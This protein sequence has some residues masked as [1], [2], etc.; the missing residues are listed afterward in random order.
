MKTLST[1]ALLRKTFNWG[2]SLQFRDSVLFHH[3]GEHRTMHADV[4]LGTSWL[5]GKRKWSEC[6]TEWTLSESNLRAHSHSDKFPLM[7]IRLIYLLHTFLN[8]YFNK[9]TPA[10]SVLSLGMIFF[11]T[12]IVHYMAS[13]CLFPL[14]NTVS[15]TS[16][17]PIVYH[18]CK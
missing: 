12:T 8:T 10:N 18:S 13:K 11:Q 6:Y 4:V 16:K 3:D 1:A 15:T 2:H 7:K 5:E 17:G 14:A 9:S